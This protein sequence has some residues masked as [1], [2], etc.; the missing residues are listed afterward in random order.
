MFTHKGKGCVEMDNPW[1]LCRTIGPL[2]LHSQRC[3][4]RDLKFCGRFVVNVF[5]ININNFYSCQNPS[6]GDEIFMHGHEK[7]D[8]ISSHPLCAF[9]IQPW[10]FF[11][12]GFSLCFSKYSDSWPL[13][14]S[15]ISITT[16]WVVG[17]TLSG[18]W[19][20]MFS[21]S[22]GCNK[23]SGLVFPM[24]ASIYNQSMIW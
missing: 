20:G 13:S 3:W 11:Y 16:S 14:C 4:L 5:E 24:Y 15:T 18:G 10:T 2:T 21:A 7:I 19:N 8:Q 23:H 17:T 9:Q 1:Q 22:P 6:G 12:L